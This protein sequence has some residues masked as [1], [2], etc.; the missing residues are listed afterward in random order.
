MRWATRGIGFSEKIDFRRVVRLALAGGSAAADLI[1]HLIPPSLLHPYVLLSRLYSKQRQI[2][3]ARLAVVVFT[4]GTRLTYDLS[5]GNRV[6]GAGCVPYFYPL[7]CPLELYSELWSFRCCSIQETQ[8]HPCMYVHVRMYTFERNSSV[9]SYHA[10]KFF[11]RFYLQPVRR[12]SI[13]RRAVN[14]E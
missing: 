9:C 10:F 4:V 6:G 3:P 11:F 12:C 8:L 5:R 13:T 14:G 2:G 7:H 1:S